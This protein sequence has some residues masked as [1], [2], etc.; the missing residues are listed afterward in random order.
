AGVI[1][2]ETVVSG[3][4][5]LSNFMPVGSVSSSVGAG[6]K[7][8]NAAQFNILYKGTGTNSAKYGGAQIRFYNNTIRE[9]RR[10]NQAW[11]IIAPST[12]LF[13]SN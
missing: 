3:I 7:T 11:G 6:T 9:T 8:L 1:R 2:D 10:F 12:F 5:T 4:N 13:P